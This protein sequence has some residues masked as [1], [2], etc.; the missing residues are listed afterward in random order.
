MNSY[1]NL[2]LKNN[3]ID[4]TGRVNGPKLRFLLPETID[5]I[6]KATIYLDHLPKV[7]IKHRI[8]AIRLDFPQIEYCPICSNNTKF[9]EDKNK[10][11]TKFCSDICAA[12]FARTDPESIKKYKNWRYSPSGVSAAKKGGENGRISQ[13]KSTGNFGFQ[14]KEIQVKCQISSQDSKRNSKFK[15]YSYNNKIFNIQG[16]EGHF[17]DKNIQNYNLEKFHNSRKLV[18]KILYKEN[19]KIRRYYP[20]FY[21]EPTNEIIEIKSVY[22]LIKDF[23]NIIEKIK[24]SLSYGFIV[25]LYVY[26]K[27]LDENVI[28]FPTTQS[29]DDVESILLNFLNTCFQIYPNECN[30]IGSH[31]LTELL[32]VQQENCVGG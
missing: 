29:S 25:S 4:I 9:S 19:N 16:Y 3:L 1:K 7:Y 12:K 17:L 14:N 8:K 10:L 21:H 20:D 11:F 28:I 23:F 2:I 6:N 31:L 27:N 18:P 13:I 15:K 22:T 30:R 26:T 24:S 32:D 5:Q